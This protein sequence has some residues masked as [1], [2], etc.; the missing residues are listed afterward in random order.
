LVSCAY[1]KHIIL[2]QNRFLVAP[3]Y[4]EIGAVNFFRKK[5]GTIYWNA[6]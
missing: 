6:G 3:Q 2:I 1:F 5:L 4:L